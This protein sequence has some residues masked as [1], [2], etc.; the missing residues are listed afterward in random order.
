MLRRKGATPE[1]AEEA[2]NRLKELGYVND[3]RFASEWVRARSE[4][5]ARP[6]G[7]RG[8]K[9]GLIRRGIDPATAAQAAES[10]MSEE[11]EFRAAAALASRRVKVY[12]GLDPETRNR[13]LW[14]YLA[15]R[16]F[17]SSIIARVLELDR[18]DFGES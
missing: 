8:L 2:V 12:Q 4:G 13:R 5:Q 18:V 3:S 1:V 10:A 14:W 11:D 15:R 7:R 17:R 16:G 6:L 9:E